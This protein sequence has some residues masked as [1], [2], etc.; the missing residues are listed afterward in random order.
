MFILNSEFRIPIPLKK[1]L[2]IATFYDGGNVFQ[3]LGF[4]DFGS[5]YSNTIGIGLRYATP[6]GPIR[7]DVGH[8]LN[9]VAG[10]KATQFFIT[11]GQAF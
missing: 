2:G 6:V 3:H 5:S 9:A 1:G 11:L 8:N 4:S 10:I 7:I